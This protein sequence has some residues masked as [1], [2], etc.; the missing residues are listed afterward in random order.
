MGYATVG[1]ACILGTQPYSK[2]EGRSILHRM[3]HDACVGKRHIGLAKSDAARI[4]QF[5][6]LREPF[7]FQTL[8]ERSNGVDMGLVETSGA[9][10]QHF[11][12]PRFVQRRIGVWRA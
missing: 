3:H 2:A 7:T 5:S 8:S 11:H 9:M 6:H 10:L 4:T 1:E 12:Q